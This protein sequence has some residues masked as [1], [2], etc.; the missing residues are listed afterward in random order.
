MT[1]LACFF[2]DTS[3]YGGAE[4]VLLTLL[5]GLD[6]RRWE[7]V[8]IH[9][10]EP[11]L[12]QLLEEA[13]NLDVPLWAVPRMPDGREGALRMPS[14]ARQLAARRPSVFH[15]HLTWERACKFGLAAAVLANVP[16]VVA[17]MELFVDV[18]MTRYVH[19]QQRLLASRVGRYV[20]VSGAMARQLHAT[21][22][23]PT[24]KIRTVHNG[25]PLSPFERPAESHLH[26]SLYGTG[27]RPIV[28]TTARLDSQKGIGYL[29][30]AAVLVPEALFVLAGDGPERAR[31]EAQ[32]GR[33][34]L[35]DRVAFLGQR[36]DVPEL[37][38]ACDLLV[39]PSLY[40][41]L[42]VSIIEAM[43]SGKP[44]VATAIPGN[45]EAV[46]DGETG[47]LV[48]PHDP[49]ALANA[50][51]TLLSDSALSGRMGAAGNARARRHFSA[52][53]MVR[54]ITDIY[55]ELLR[56]RGRISEPDRVY[57]G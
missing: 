39:L 33:L 6:R 22:S 52:E 8:L 12:A 30:E 31:M 1:E 2:T 26:S 40:E 38:A 21:Y 41:G 27:Q 28:L 16:S 50:I 37:L 20:T 32:A 42:S 13:R 56:A 49:A 14:F 7:P 34:G 57:E 46:V 18:P 24:H 53:T 23:I 4:K 36:N 15:A 47:L 54:R 44:V 11:G 17:M 43:A 29:L 9:H 19:L 51:R 45:D 5:A 48:P 35:A 25:V 3:G 10:P 55:D